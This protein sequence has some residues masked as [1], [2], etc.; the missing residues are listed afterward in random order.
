MIETW[1]IDKIMESK[2]PAH[3]AI[4]LWR[5]CD[6]PLNA[7]SKTRLQQKIPGNIVDFNAPHQFV[8]VYHV[9]LETKQLTA[10]GL[11]EIYYLGVKRW[12]HIVIQTG[13]RNCIHAAEWRRLSPEG[14]HLTPRDLKSPSWS[15]RP[16][17]PVNQ[18]ENTIWVKIRKKLVDRLDIIM[19][20]DTNQREKVFG[21][22][23]QAQIKVVYSI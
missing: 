20:W 8:M 6:L 17:V 18:R 9:L 3:Q 16:N 11:E 1:L 22:H 4:T 21:T 23:V 7:Y 10:R 2:Y 13:V 5:R 14:G 19:K 15:I 12:G